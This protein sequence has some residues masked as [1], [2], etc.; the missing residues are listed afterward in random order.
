MRHKATSTDVTKPIIFVFSGQGSQYFQMGRDLF[1]REEIFR[2]SMLD[3]D[4]SV[5]KLTGASVI[6][7]IYND[8]RSKETPF[9]DVLLTHPA[10]FMIECSL[11]KAVIKRWSSPHCVLG[12]SIGAFAAVCIAGVLG[13]EEA[14]AAIMEHAFAV[15]RSCTKGGMTAVLADVQSNASLLRQ[16]GVELAAVNSPS[17][18]VVSASA[19]NLLALEQ[20]LAKRNIAFQRLPVDYAF[21]SNTMD[22]AY[23]AFLRGCK[24]LGYKQP[25]LPIVCCVGASYVDR[26][27][28]GFLW[29]ST[30]RIVRL[31]DTI[32]KLEETGP[33]LYIDCGPSGSLAT[34]IKHAL[35]ESSQ[36]EICSILHPYRRV[37]A[38]DPLH[39][40]RAG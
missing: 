37:S 7:E 27:D 12:A 17:H 33:C 40:Y 25:N 10:I 38:G 34:A 24:A 6:S 5:K 26:V 32:I 20:S 9:C 28:A 16:Y 14:L 8:Q 30:R 11:A 3:L 18:F 13:E 23:D 22:S 36:S 39:L 15:E 19:R 21:H 29:N 1:Q 31:H 2:V 4:A 35:P